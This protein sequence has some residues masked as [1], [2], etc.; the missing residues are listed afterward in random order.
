MRYTGT[1]LIPIPGSANFNTPAAGDPTYS[2][3]LY[4]AI[5]DK[6]I[7]RSFVALDDRH[8]AIDSCDDLHCE[9]LIFRFHGYPK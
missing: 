1:Y 6:I 5:L 9:S 7:E 2:L 8:L 4:M 3:T